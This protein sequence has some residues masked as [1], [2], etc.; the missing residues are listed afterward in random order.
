[1]SLMVSS[2][3]VFSQ[4]KFVG[5]WQNVDDEDGKPKSNIQ[6]YEE[7]GELKAKVIKLLPNA[8][9]KICDKCVGAN[10][11]KSIEGMSIL[12]GLKKISNIEY[13]NGQILNPKN[14]KVYDCTLTIENDGNRMKVRGYVGVSVFGKTQYWTRLN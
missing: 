5:T 3:L 10:K 4:N 6:V 11:N 13:G 1:L 2:Q 7:A 12:W 14:G 8:K 9:L